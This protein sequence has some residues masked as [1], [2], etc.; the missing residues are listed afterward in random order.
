MN[1]NV[2]CTLLF[3]CTFSNF[4]LPTGITF[5]FHSNYFLS[6]FKYIFLV[7]V[8]EFLFIQLLWSPTLAIFI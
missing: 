1:S 5:T 4:P 7:E 8:N 3:N 6:N 2:Q